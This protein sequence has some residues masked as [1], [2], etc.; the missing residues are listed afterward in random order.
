MSESERESLEQQLEFR[1]YNWRLQE[2]PGCAWVI[3]GHCWQLAVQTFSDTKG[4]F[5]PRIS[6]EILNVFNIQIS[7]YRYK[8]HLSYLVAIDES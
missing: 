5:R 1:R 2:L 7:G 8:N 4:T 6:F 3:T